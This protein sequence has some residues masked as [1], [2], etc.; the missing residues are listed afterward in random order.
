[1][2]RAI[3]QSVI[4]EPGSLDVMKDFVEGQISDMCAPVEEATEL[5][6]IVME[7]MNAEVVEGVI[8]F[9]PSAGLPTWY[10]LQSRTLSKV[11]NK[12]LGM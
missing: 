3:T 8:K 6:E 2:W 1:V 7:V 4:D 9:G 11:D 12:S 5:R 10:C